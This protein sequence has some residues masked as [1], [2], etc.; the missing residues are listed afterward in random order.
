ML[1]PL[2]G[3]INC[4]L[5]IL[6]PAGQKIFACFGKAD[7]LHSR[8]ARRTPASP[9]LSIGT[10]RRAPKALDPYCLDLATVN[11]MDDGF[12]IELCSLSGHNIATATCSRN[13]VK[14]DRAF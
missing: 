6:R 10:Q 7:A 4:S 11:T 1:E 3:V 2:L 5:P 8:N 13:L 9:V 12:Q 14:P